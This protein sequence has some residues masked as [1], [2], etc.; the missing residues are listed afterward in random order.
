MAYQALGAG[1]G[2][3]SR[4]GIV[5]G[6][7]ARVWFRAEGAEAT[8]FGIAVGLFAR[9]WLRVEGVGGVVGA[10]VELAAAVAGVLNRGDAGGS[11]ARMNVGGGSE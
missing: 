9:V 8:G 4:V 5:V 7:F 6:V 1:D 3:A 10:V 2:S 11:L